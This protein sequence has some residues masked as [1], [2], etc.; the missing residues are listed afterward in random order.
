MY[1]P[2]QELRAFTRVS[3]LSGQSTTARLT[4]GARAFAYWH[5]ELHRWHVAPGDYQLRVGASS[6]DVRATASVLLDGEPLVAP[7]SAE[8][9]A[10]T[11]H[12]HPDGGRW[13]SEVFTGQDLGGLLLDP[14]E[15]RMLRAIP[16]IRLART[17]G[18]GLD[19]PLVDEPLVDVAVR[20]FA[21]S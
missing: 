15:G 8:S 14:L 3:L 6:R 5:D 17:P 21:A 16:L 13:L 19:E 20:R 4:L 18:T 10:E 1:R 2:D 7:L 9:D 11:W 12:A